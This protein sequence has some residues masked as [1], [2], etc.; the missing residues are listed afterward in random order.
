VRRSKVLKR[1]QE[2]DLQTQSESRNALKVAEE[3]PRVE[4]FFFSKN[5]WQ[6]VGEE[7]VQGRIEGEGR[8]KDGH[9]PSFSCSFFCFLKSFS[10][11]P[12]NDACQ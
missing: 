12:F 3:K 2:M 11:C 7:E 9:K 10:N 8:V 5:L 1:L 6:W 4:I